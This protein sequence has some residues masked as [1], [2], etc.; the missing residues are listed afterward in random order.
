[1]LKSNKKIT[2]IEFRDGEPTNMIKDTTVVMQSI[3]PN[4]IRPELNLN[5]DTKILFWTLFHYN[6]I[7][8]FL[9]VK[10]LRHIHH[11]SAFFK[12]IDSVI[13]KKYYKNLKVFATELH[14]KA[15]LFFM[16]YS[17][18]EITNE[19]LFLNLIEPSIIPICI[20][21]IEKNKDVVKNNDQSTFNICWIG[22]IE[23]FKTSILQYSINRV[24]RYA[25]NSQKKIKFDIVG[26]GKDLE[27]V[28]SNISNSKFFIANFM[29]TMGVETLKDYLIINI[30]LLMSMGTAA[31]EGG[32]LG[33]PTVLLDASYK[34]I[35]NDYEFRWLF[36]SDGS[37]VAKFIQSKSFRNNGQSIDKIIESVKKNHASL[38]EKCLLYVD[39][40]HSITFVSD[41]LLSAV[42]KATFTWG[43]IDPLLINKNRIRKLYDN[44]RYNI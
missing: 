4:S 43:E 9:P 24:K 13:K 27:K 7:P 19:S 2:L 39:K 12:W 15:S 37:N 36:D 16:N 25:E 34:E 31:L 11:R 18:Y 1:M 32:K 29:G 28:K 41:K 17:T 6:L 23:D 22:R 42:N 35:P 21:E 40:N 30:D 20:D 26:Y 8:D 10:G 14:E 5:P 38:G 33:I 44:Y 3:L